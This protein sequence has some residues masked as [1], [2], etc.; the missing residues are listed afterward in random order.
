MNDSSQVCDSH[1]PVVEDAESNN[2]FDFIAR[3]YVTFGIESVGRESPLV[4]AEAEDA[5]NAEKEGYKCVPR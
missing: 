5:S 1:S 4:E 2:G 3:K